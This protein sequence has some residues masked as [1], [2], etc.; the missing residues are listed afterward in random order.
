MSIT[1]QETTL[2]YAIWINHR[3]QEGCQEHA[4]GEMESTLF[5]QD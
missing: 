5:D 1:P 4:E 3:R 2:S